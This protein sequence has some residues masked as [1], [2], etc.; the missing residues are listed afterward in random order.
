MSPK[1]ADSDLFAKKNWLQDSNE[2]P[3]CPKSLPLQ[4]L[5]PTEGIVAAMGQQFNGSE[6][7]PMTAS[8]TRLQRIVASWSALPDE[9]KCAMEAL[10]AMPR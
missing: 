6:C 3:V 1:R 2:S 9:T 10:A 7:L 5:R 4:V 8:D